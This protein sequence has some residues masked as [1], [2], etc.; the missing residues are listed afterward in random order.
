MKHLAQF[1]VGT[2]LK[3]GSIFGR[4]QQELEHGHHRMVLL[5]APLRRVYEEVISTFV[6]G[7]ESGRTSIAEVPDGSKAFEWASAK[8]L[9][10]LNAHH[11]Q[12][13]ARMILAAVA[14]GDQ[15]CAE[16]LADVLSKWW[17][18]FAYQHEPIALYGK[19]KYL[20]LEHLSLNW[21]TLYGQLGLTEIEMQ[22]GGGDVKALQHGV[23]LAALKN[24]WTDIRF[25]TIELLL[26]WVEKDESPTL[27]NSLA[28]EIASGLLNG[29]QWKGGGTQTESLSDLSAAAYLTAKVRQFAASGEWRGGYVGSL[30]RFVERVKDMERPDMVSSRIYSF[31]GADDVDSLQ[32]QQLALLAALSA[33]EWTVGD[34]LRRQIDIW[35]AR[36][37]TSIDIL[38]QKTKDW[39]RRMEHAGELSPRL[40]PAL[41]E[42]TGKTHGAAQGRSWAKHGIE[43]LRDLV[44][45]KRMDVLEAEPIDPARLLQLAQFASRKGFGQ[46]SGEFPL[47]LFRTVASDATAHQN[48]T[49][50]INEVR[51]GE[52]TRTE[53]DQRPIN[54]ADYWAETMARQVGVVVLTDVLLECTFHAIV[55]PDAEAYWAALKLE[56]ARMFGRGEHPVLMLDNAT[57]P[58]WVWQWQHA[59]YGSEYARPDDLRVQRFEGK[60]DGYICNF[61]DIEVYSAPLQPGK[62]ILISREAFDALVFTEFDAGRF[63]EVKVDERSDSKLLV[64]L[65]LNFSRRVAVGAK[66]AV[67]LNYAEETKP[68]D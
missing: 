6:S 4:R 47:Q 13:T 9:G 17:G 15:A 1:S 30:S 60:G 10:R 41:M 55:T 34:S 11:I 29:K 51:K 38:R 36:Q 46:A 68:T 45:E 58:E 31:S 48:F 42:R 24:Y 67:E 21:A 40:L 5:R 43:A 3:S 63:V 52:L 49:L 2:T 32:E 35:I 18:S 22:W 54:E 53:M 8:E 26:S 25:L 65:K 14:R 50:G 33:N 19:T 12:E 66:A 61:N 27:E 23:L 39:L 56:T 28:M 44:E 37:Y 20:T 64:D 16:W 7:W 57:R 59:D 62:S